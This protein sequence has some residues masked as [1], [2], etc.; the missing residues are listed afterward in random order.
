M[1]VLCGFKL[2]H[3]PTCVLLVDEM[4]LRKAMAKGTKPDMRDFCKIQLHD[5]FHHG[6]PTDVVDLQVR[7]YAEQLK[8]F[9]L[10]VNAKDLRVWQGLSLVMSAER[11]NQ[12]Q[13]QMD[14]QK[15]AMQKKKAKD[16]ELKR[17]KEERERAEKKSERSAS[18]ALRRCV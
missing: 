7:D 2:R 12:I 6:A 4:C 14:A 1:C 3:L 16:A 18:N 5:L 10:E 9:F 13:Q 15:A 17:K 8:T 11:H